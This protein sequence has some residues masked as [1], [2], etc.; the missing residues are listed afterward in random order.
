MPSDRLTLALDLGAVDLPSKGPIGLFTDALVELPPGLSPD[1]LR[2]VTPFWPVVDRMQSLGVTTASPSDRPPLAASIVRVS[3]SRAASRLALG[4]A[5]AATVPGG[6]VLVD[7]QKTDG[8][9]ALL[10]E[11]RA[12][13][14]VPDSFV[15]HHGR[16]FWLPADAALFEDWARLVEDWPKAGEFHTAPGGFSA[17]GPDPAS[18]AL[19]AALPERL[20]G[21]IADLGAGWGY[22]AAHVLSRPEV[23]QVDLVEAH[24]GALD[25]ARRNI[26]DARARFHWADATTWEPDA[27]VNTV[28]MNPPFHSGRAADPSLGQAFL[29]AAARILQRDGTVWMVANRQLPYEA[30]IAE[31]FARQETLPAPAGFK[32]ITAREPRRTS[33]AA[34]AR[35]NREAVRDL[36]R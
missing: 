23:E 4:Q 1:R 13:A 18:V 12:R 36:F 17:D 25:A 3:R 27:S 19:A 28:V 14:E 32:I 15:K 8:I 6:P 33:R 5:M 7:G 31:L 9:D 26:P 10:R 29:A 20:A 30:T 35:S 16:L 22:L 21:R 34:A 11:V 24:R 2:L